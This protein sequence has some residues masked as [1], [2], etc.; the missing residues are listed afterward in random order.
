MKP[1]AILL[2]LFLI[3]LFPADLDGTQSVRDKSKLIAKR[4]HI[5]RIEVKGNESFTTDKIKSKLSCKEDGFWQSLRLKGRNRLTKA[6]LHN[7]QAVLDYFYHSEGFIDADIKVDFHGDLQEHTAVVTVDIDEGVRYRIADV[8]ISGDLGRFQWKV[9]HESKKL[10]VG[11]WLNL[12]LIDVIRR[13]IKTI[14]ANNGYPYASIIV[15][16]TR[17]SVLG[18]VDIDIRISQGNL[19]VFGTVLIDSNQFIAPAVSQRIFKKEIAFKEGEVYSRD[20]LITS[21]QRLLRT[22]LFSYIALRPPK[23]MSHEDSLMPDFRVT[24]VARTPKYVNLSTGAGQDPALDL[25]WDLAASVG[26]RNIGGSGRKVMFESSASFAEVDNIVRLIRAGIEFGYV[27]PYLFGIRMPLITRLRFEPG[28]KAVIQDYSIETIALQVTAVR[29]FSLATK[30]SISGSY[31]RIRVYNAANPE[32]EETSTNGKLVLQLDRDSRPLD[33]KFNP[34]SG[35]LTEYRLESVGG[36]LGGDDN[37]LKLLFNWAKYNRFL[38]NSVFASRLR[39]GWVDELTGEDVVPSRDRFFLG[40]A[41]TI[42][43]FEENS[44]FPVDNLGIEGGTTIGLLNLEIRAPL[45][46]Q[47]WGSLFFDSGFNTLGL[48]PINQ[49]R[50]SGGAGIQFTSPVGPIRLDY[51]RR[52]AVNDTDPGGRFHLSILYAF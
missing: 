45:F 3:S 36:L 26:N 37:F 49:F 41:F 11:D 50:Y 52:I 5:E 40:G 7:D 31:E 24:G 43:G 16:L 21:Q 29:E 25:V 39:C 8:T 1:A 14:F 28:L 15:T 46:W 33:A 6:K 9:Y 13:R 20:K 12:S 44:I 19:V 4:P 17:E 30:L 10:R 27:E 48:V 38:G 42:R 32:E 34:S 22:N 47:F 18:S 23:Y 35:S 2:T 51:G